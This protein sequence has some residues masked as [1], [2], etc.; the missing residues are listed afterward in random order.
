MLYRMTKVD[1]FCLI[2]KGGHIFFS[3]WRLRETVNGVPKNKWW[4]LNVIAT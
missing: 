2:D 4:V 3:I 1:V